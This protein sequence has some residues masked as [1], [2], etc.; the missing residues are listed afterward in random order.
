MEN[1]NGINNFKVGKSTRILHLTLQSNRR[2]YVGNPLHFSFETRK[3]RFRYSITNTYVLGSKQTHI[4]SKADG[5]KRVNLRLKFVDN[6]K[7][8][9]Q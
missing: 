8:A 4:Q 5:I 7:F 3:P 1:C 2:T 9:C 6:R